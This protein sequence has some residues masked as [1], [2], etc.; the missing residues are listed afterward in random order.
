MEQNLMTTRIVGS[1]H[2]SVN[3]SANASTKTEK[4]IQAI[5]LYITMLK[6]KTNHFFSRLYWL[7]FH[8]AKQFRMGSGKS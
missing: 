6:R 5:L 3:Y 4:A 1:C 7:N 8:L 2:Q